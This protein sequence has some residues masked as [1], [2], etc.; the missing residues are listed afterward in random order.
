[1]SSGVTLP[2]RV[3]EAHR[4][5]QEN[6]QWVFEHHSELEKFRGRFIA[7]ADGQVLGSAWSAEQLH[8]RFRRDRS[9]VYVHFMAPK[10][11][12]WVL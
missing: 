9:D 5:F 2:K 4:K 7:V 11:W 6:A 1:M 12:A 10:D 8:K 3:L